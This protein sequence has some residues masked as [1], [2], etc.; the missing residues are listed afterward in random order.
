ML[1]EV[2]NSKTNAPISL[3][4]DS[5]LVSTEG[6]RIVNKLDYISN[7]PIEI[8]EKIAFKLNVTDYNNLR[9]SSELMK[10]SLKSIGFICNKLNGKECIGD[11]RDL[12]SSIFRKQIDELIKNDM[13]DDLSLAIQGLE[14]SEGVYPFELKTQCY[15]NNKKYGDL[16]MRFKMKVSGNNCN[17]KPGMRLLRKDSG[18]VGVELLSLEFKTFDINKDILDVIFKSFDTMFKEISTSDRLFV[19][20]SAYTLMK[21][22]IDKTQEMKGLIDKTPNNIEIADVS[23]CKSKY[24]ELIVMGRITVDYFAESVSALR[25]TSK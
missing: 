23:A 17:N 11:L 2:S 25:T 9:N 16:L 21:G 12:Y 19:A 1:N 8:K 20:A 4:Q 14:M 24:P 13:S 5:Q 18:E 3:C 6:G 22:L 10:T 15:K 7:L